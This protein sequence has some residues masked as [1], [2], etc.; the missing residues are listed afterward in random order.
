MSFQMTYYVLLPVK[1]S[2]QSKTANEMIISDVIT[3]D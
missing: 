1:Y 2:T 3:I